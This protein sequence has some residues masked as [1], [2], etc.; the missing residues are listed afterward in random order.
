MYESR[1]WRITKLLRMAKAVLKTFIGK[2]LRLFVREAEV[3][4]HRFPMTKPV[5]IWILHRAPFLMRLVTRFSKNKF[6]TQGIIKKR[7]VEFDQLGAPR[8]MS[9]LSSLPAH[10]SEG[11]VTF[12]EVGDDVG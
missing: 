5:A 8:I 7:I 4:V 6:S 11:P 9:A 3:L 12:L 1:S 2:V 10:I